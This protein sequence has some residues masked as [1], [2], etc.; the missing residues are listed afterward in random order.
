MLREIAIQS[1]GTCV[2]VVTTGPGGAPLDFRFVASAFLCS[3][4]GYFVTCAHAIDLS[5]P[6]FVGIPTSNEEFQNS[7]GRTYN[8]MALTVAQFDPI[9][10]VALLKAAHR[11]D[12]VAAKP[13]E[14]LGDERNIPLGSSVGYIGFP[15]ASR[16]LQS[17]KLSSAIISAKVLN[18]AGTR[19]LQIDSSVN[20]GNS[21]G[22]LIDATTKKVVGIVSGRYSPG[23]NTTV[24]WVAGVPL[25]QDSNISYATGISYAVDLMK[26]EGIYE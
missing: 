15:F 21:G 8:F 17:G 13:S 26:V 14:M 3:N 7:T 24:A 1:M 11:L 5:K 12:A 22:P 19:T 9:N 23:G 18:E 20:D 25:G 16:G 6:L 2:M 10:D 4:K